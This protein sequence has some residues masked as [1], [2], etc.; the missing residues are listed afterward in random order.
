MA[1][2]LKILAQT[3]ALSLLL[4]QWGCST[5]RSNIPPEKAIVFDASARNSK[6]DDIVLEHLEQLGLPPSE[7]CSDAVFVRRVYL[8][9]IGTLPTPQETRSFLADKDRLRQ[10][11]PPASAH[12]LYRPLDHVAVG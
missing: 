8:D 3:I 1:N 10:S 11:V 4:T 2:A 6:I 7:Q 12:L 9:A 5:S